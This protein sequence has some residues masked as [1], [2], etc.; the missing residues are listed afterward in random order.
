MGASIDYCTQQS[1]LSTSMDGENKIFN[2][3]NRFKHY[4]TTN[5]TL[6]KILEGKSQPKEPN[7][8]CND[9]DI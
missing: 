8:T 9:T 4:V 3:K 6:Q 2:D 7:Y 1:F 5:P